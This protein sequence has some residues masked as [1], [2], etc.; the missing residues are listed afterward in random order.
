MPSLLVTDGDERAAL[1]VVRSLGK[2]GYTV[3]V[4]G[5][6]RR[7][8][9]AVSRLAHASFVTPDPLSSP[10][11]FGETVISYAAAQ[12]LRLVLPVTE[13]SLLAVLAVRDRMPDVAV[14]FPPVDVFRSVNDKLALAATARD[15]GLAYPPQWVLDTRDDAVHLDL[16]AIPFPVVLKPSRSVGES[17]GTRSKQRVRHARD[18]NE[19]RAQ[20]ATLSPAAF[21]L[22]VQRRIVGPGQGVFLLRWNGTI[23]AAFAH[24]RLLEKPPSGG[25][26][27]YAEA[28]ALDPALL[29]Q[30]ERLLD[31]YGWQ[32]VAMIEY[33]IDSA[34]GTPYL[35]EINGRF[36][37]SLQ[38][39]IDAGVDFPRLLVECALGEPVATHAT[40]RV[41]QRGRWWWGEVDHVL[42]RFRRS[43]AQLALPED[44]PSRGRTLAQFLSRW[45]PGEGDAVFQFSDPIPFLYETARWFRGQ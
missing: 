22:L 23:V 2:A 7:T 16:D 20:I 33:K 30:S 17:N 40:Y 6:R 29:A 14:P 4:G 32:G 10:D 24:R 3:H 21:P 26:S 36:W 5:P 25:V 38:L 12:G 44:A 31:A 45:R 11:E 27:V 37:G 8:L 19:F 41:G 9:A 43:D 28:V 1:A 42:A 18:A 15:L 34:T 13:A 39:A 35:M